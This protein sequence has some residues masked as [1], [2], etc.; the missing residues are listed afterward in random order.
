[1]RRLIEGNVMTAASHTQVPGHDGLFGFGGKC[2]PKDLNQFIAHCIA[3]HV[4]PVMSFGALAR[5]TVDRQRGVTKSPGNS[6]ENP[7]QLAQ[8][9][10]S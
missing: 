3:T 10:V 9:I 1:V 6:P 5:S 7:G 2:L 4:E 8:N